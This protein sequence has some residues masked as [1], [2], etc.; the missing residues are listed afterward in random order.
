MPTDSS[1]SVP[2]GMRNNIQQQAITVMR[3]AL[4][5]PQT[6]QGSIFRVRNGPVLLKQL[7]GRLSVAADATVANLNPVAHPASGVA[8]VALATPTAIASTAAGTLLSPAG[9]G[10]GGALGKAGALSGLDREIVVDI[11]T[12]DL[13]T[14]GSNAAARAYWLATYEPLVPG[15]NLFPVLPSGT[16]RALDARVVGPLR[17]IRRRGA[18]IPQTAQAAIFSVLGGPILVWAFSGK[19]TLAANATATNLTVVGNSAAAGIADV[20]LCTAT[21]IASTA[22]G[23]ILA[24]QVAGIGSALGIGGAAAMLVTPV[25]VDV[26]TIDLLTSANNP[27]QA[28]WNVIWQP[29]HP[30]GR[31]VVA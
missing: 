6:A 21:A 31:L 22:L 23:N 2:Y 13:L 11:G 28:E 14:S 29:L 8:D 30:S 16:V 18:A 4:A 24:L 5:L 19:V 9:A 1:L 3:P 7:V 25:V 20:N 27:M 17:R 26:G 12:I 15:A 10:I